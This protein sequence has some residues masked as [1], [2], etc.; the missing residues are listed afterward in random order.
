MTTHAAVSEM[1][2]S[3]RCHHSSTSD[4]KSVSVGHHDV[5]EA[6][7]DINLTDQ[8]NLLPFRQI[9]VVFLGLASCI[10]VTTLDNTIVATALPTISAVFNA[11]SVASWI[12]SATLL[13]STAFQPL[14]GRFSE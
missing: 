3:P 10:I 6:K 13:T 9:V 8:T 12:P 5:P 1:A 4:D 7:Q 14:Y 2:I 11:G